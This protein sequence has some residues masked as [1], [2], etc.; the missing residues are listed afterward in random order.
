MEQ[1]KKAIDYGLTLLV[2][3]ITSRV[4]EREIAN[5]QEEIAYR[6]GIIDEA[7]SKGEIESA[8]AGPYVEIPDLVSEPGARVYLRPA[9]F[10]NMETGDIVCGDVY[11][12]VYADGSTHETNGLATL[13]KLAEATA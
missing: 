12:V 3:P 11:R 10:G 6:Q 2:D 5:M 4:T 8:S 13:K 1:Q 7:K 9:Y